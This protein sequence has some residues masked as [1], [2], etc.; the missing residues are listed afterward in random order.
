VVTTSGPWSAADGARL[1]VRVRD[2]LE[3]LERA[4]GWTRGVLVEVR[5]DLAGAPTP[6]AGW[7]LLDLLRHMV[8]SLSA[9]AEGAAGSVALATVPVDR[10]ARPEELARSLRD[11]GCAVLGAWVH[12]G[13][14]PVDLGARSLRRAVVT[15]VG[16]LEVAVHGWDVAR[17]CG[18]TAELPP[19]LAA[20]LLPVAVRRVGPGDRPGSF[21]PV[22]E[23]LRSDPAGVLLAHLGRHA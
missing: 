13:T 7:T 2:D 17:S 23:A 14:R 8:D 11:L 15:E 3:L 9:L 18:S 5:D 22:V 6:C 21:G 20:G 10:S 12:A 4:L 19:L 16:A 1:P